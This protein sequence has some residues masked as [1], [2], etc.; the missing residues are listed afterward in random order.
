MGRSREEKT[1]Q[2]EAS[3]APQSSDC[4]AQLRVCQWHGGRARSRHSASPPCGL[5]LFL[6]GLAR[7]RPTANKPSTP[8]G[9]QLRTLNNRFAMPSTARR[10]RP[11][12]APTRVRASG[13]TPPQ[14]TAKSTKTLNRFPC[15]HGASG[16]SRCR[17][18]LTP[19]DTH[20]VS[21]SRHTSIKSGEAP[22]YAH[23]DAP[24]ASTPVSKDL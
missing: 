6:E 3:R 18:A 19:S 20:L 4:G 9:A 16:R 11:K 2:S 14:R 5:V 12:A 21:L 15:E 10:F 24:E 7:S 22:V 1:A 8:R 23:R 17:A 13:R